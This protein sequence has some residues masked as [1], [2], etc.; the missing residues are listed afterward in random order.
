MN[1]LYQIENKKAEFITET[2]I[3]PDIVILPYTEYRELITEISYINPT[4]EH[5][6]TITG[7][8]IVKSDD[9]K[10]ISVGY[11]NLNKVERM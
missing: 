7:L 3:T 1:I 5:T 10:D 11:T 2:G 4:I 6:E 8:E 9:V